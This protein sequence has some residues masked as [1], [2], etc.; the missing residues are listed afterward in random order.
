MTSIVEAAC[1]PSA[2]TSKPT[3]KTSITSFTALS[4]EGTLRHDS[5][6]VRSSALDSWL[7]GSTAAI[8][9]PASPKHRPKGLASHG[10]P[11]TVCTFGRQEGQEVHTCPFAQPPGLSSGCGSPPAPHPHTLVDTHTH[12]SHTHTH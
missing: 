12:T 7:K 9:S 8:A 10:P 2:T 5:F 1:M 3:T 6:L 4:P 11:T